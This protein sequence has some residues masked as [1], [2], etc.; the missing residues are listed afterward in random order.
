MSS[1]KTPQRKAFRGKCLAIVQAAKPG[2]IRVKA[3]S[4]GLAG[5]EIRFSA[6]K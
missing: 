3:L 2:A 6:I 1:T 4:D 5:D